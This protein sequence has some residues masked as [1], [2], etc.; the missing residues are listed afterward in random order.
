[1]AETITDEKNS[2]QLKGRSFNDMLY[3]NYVNNFKIVD[4]S[5]EYDMHVV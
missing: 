5:A 2:T 1:M 3:E 4:N